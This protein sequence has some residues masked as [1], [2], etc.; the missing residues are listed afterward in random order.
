MTPV[1][2]FRFG[3]TPSRDLTVS[4]RLEYDTEY[5][6][7]ALAGLNLDH[8]LDRR[9][10]YYGKLMQC[11]YRRWDFSSSPYDPAIM[12]G[13]V[14]NLVRYTFVQA[15]FEHELCDAIAWS[16]YLRWDCRNGQLDS[17]GSWIDY[18]TDC[19]GFRLLLEYNGSYT[20]IDGYERERDFSVGFYIYLRA[21]GA[22]SANLFN[23]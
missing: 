19:L 20:R 3:W 16:P 4:G 21:F 15:G 10:S 18:R 6:T 1:P 22:E 9:F 7:L 13:D 14:F 17:V 5:N 23:Q 12:S 11:D 2:G 8:R